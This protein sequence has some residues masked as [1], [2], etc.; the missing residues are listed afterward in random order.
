MNRIQK[1]SSS[2]KIEIRRLGTDNFNGY[3]KGKEKRGAAQGMLGQLDGTGNLVTVGGRAR[4]MSCDS[5]EN[6]VGR[7]RSSLLE[8]IQKGIRK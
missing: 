5:G 4:G 1:N 3:M 8:N 7:R 6:V 2:R